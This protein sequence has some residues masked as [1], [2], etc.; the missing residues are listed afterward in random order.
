[1]AFEERLAKIA[2]LDARVQQNIVRQAK[3][4]AQE[5]KLL[6]SLSPAGWLYVTIPGL[7]ETG[8]L[9]ARAIFAIRKGIVNIDGFI[10]EL[11]IAK[12]VGETGLNKEE[13]LIVKQ[14]FEKAETLAKD[15][16]V[17]V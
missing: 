3:L 10:A 5:A 9:L 15:Q 8:E 13:L 7:H 4:R 14:A 1:M 16:N 2:E 17:L 6:K 12:I 11:K